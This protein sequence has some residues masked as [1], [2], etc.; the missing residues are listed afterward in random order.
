MNEQIKQRWVEAIRSRQE[1]LE[2]GMKKH[3]MKAVNHPV[4][5]ILRD[6]Y[7]E[8]TGEEYLSSL[9]AIERERKDNV[10]K[11]VFIDDTITKTLRWA[12]IKC[13]PQNRRCSPS[14]AFN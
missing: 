8:E 5:H 13:D 6:M 1:I 7:L 4:Y 11:V 10:T 2:N 3:I 12:G 9:D 14:S